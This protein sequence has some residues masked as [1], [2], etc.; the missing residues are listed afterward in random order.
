M[1]KQEYYDKM[2]D[3]RADTAGCTVNT[4]VPYTYQNPIIPSNPI[5]PLQYGWV[6]PRCNKVH[7]PWKSSCECP[8]STITVYPYNVP[9]TT[10]NLR[11]VDIS[12]NCTIT[13][14]P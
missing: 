4:T 11:N 2:S 12:G 14:K 6:C 9:G 13:A 5:P 7:A 3:A 8:V 1:I 10:A